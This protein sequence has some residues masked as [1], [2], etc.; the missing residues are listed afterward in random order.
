[1]TIYVKEL[2]AIEKNVLL[3]TGELDKILT[4]VRNKMSNLSFLSQID[5]S[6]KKRKY[7]QLFYCCCLS[8][9]II[10]KKSF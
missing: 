3:I 9:Y 5:A 10:L 7:H 6:T 4:N 8:M 1:M 2:E